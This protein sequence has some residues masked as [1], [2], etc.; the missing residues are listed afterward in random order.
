MPSRACGRSRPPG[1]AVV[2]Q[3]YIP[4]PATRHYY[5]EGFVDSEGAVRIWFARQRLRMYPP[6][7]GN[8][9]Y[10]AS[11]HW[12]RSRAP[13]PPWTLLAHLQYRGIFSAEFKRD[14]RDGEFKL[15]EVNARP[16]WYVDF[17]VRCGRGRRLGVLPRRAGAPGGGAER[18]RVG[19]TCMYPYCDYFASRGD[20]WS[21]PRFGGG[22]ASSSA[23]SSRSSH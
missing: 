14:D 18:Y 11:V 5:V 1:S 17:A 12:T 23:R 21:L 3:E 8:S 19:A 6:D 4:G 20:G 7:F 22:S 10:F 2:L 13:S 15:L 9:T 16:W